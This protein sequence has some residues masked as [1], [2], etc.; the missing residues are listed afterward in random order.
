MDKRLGRPALTRAPF[1]DASPYRARAS[2]ALCPLP[3]GEG[4]SPLQRGTAAKREPDRA[5]HQE[6]P[7]QGVA[8][9][10]R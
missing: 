9:K 5:K 1:F 3:E 4:L 6:K 7:R 2:R 8:R 10:T